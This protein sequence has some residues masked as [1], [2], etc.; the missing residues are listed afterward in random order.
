MDKEMKK[1]FRNNVIKFVVGMLLLGV[2]FMYIQKHPAEKA[3]I[4]S[5]FEVLYQRI[6]VFFYKIM[7]KDSE[8]L[9]HKFD[10][11]KTFG[12]LISTAENKWCVES[13]ILDELRET[14][15]ALKK[16]SIADLE[17]NI[18]NYKRKMG[19]YKAMIDATC[20]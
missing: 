1:I 8:W 18:G 3:S 11:E 6:E 15:I 9:K 14:M 2:S 12:E 19:E 16:E 7:K 20:K 10:L 5:G 13:N 17:N 4:F